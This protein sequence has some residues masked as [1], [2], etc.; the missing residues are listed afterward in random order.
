MTLN[1]KKALLLLLIFFVGI[2]VVSASEDFDD[3]TIE[4]TYD[5]QQIIE[6]N[7]YEPVEETG[8]NENN[9][10]DEDTTPITVTNTN[11]DSVMSSLS[12]YDTITFDDTFS[13]KTMNINA[14]VTIT[15]TSTA[16]FVN[17]QISI[18]SN[19]V[20]ISNLN[21]ANTDVAGSVITATDVNN[22]IL[23]L[24]NITTTNTNNYQKAIGITF[25]N[26]NNSNIT[27]SNITVSGYPQNLGW[28]NSTGVWLSESQVT[29][30]SMSQV[31]YINVTNNYLI[32]SNSTEPINDNTTIEAITLKTDSNNVN[33]TDNTI[34]ING[35][36]YVYAI[37]LSDVVN[38]ANISN[39]EIIMFSNNYLNGIQLDK[40]KYSIVYNNTILGSTILESTYVPSFE[41]VAYGI[42]VTT[43]SFPPIYGE[44][45]NNTIRANYIDLNATIVYAIELYLANDTIIDNNE[46]TATG[47]ITIGIGLY[48][49]SNNRIKENI[50]DLEAHNKTISPQF[51][52]Q[53][54]K[55]SCGIIIVG[56]SSSTNNN[57]TDNAIMVS[58]DQYRT[59]T[60][61]CVIV[62]ATGNKVT[63]NELE[64]TYD[65]ITPVLT[66]NN[67]V[68]YDS[69]NTVNSNL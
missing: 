35:S 32:V 59:D 62:R 18:T 25:N 33:I 67:A 19:G 38:Y 6:S 22:I 24:N 20:T 29:G 46:I 11:Y 49:S 41:R 17:S 68:D 8:T 36:N 21:I 15:A 48:N 69:G 57:V 10:N 58:D 34:E 3:N 47:N 60:L 56:N 1:I 42:V 23:D 37:S 51:Y 63:E 53:I 43:S 12:S 66:G 14:P 28:D 55:T 61:Y 39:N 16:K 52:E 26:V 2:N 50:I 65:G 5:S 64:T 31:N 7:N 54:P 44:S 40:T 13:G 30:I 27:N 45:T 4:P 9:D